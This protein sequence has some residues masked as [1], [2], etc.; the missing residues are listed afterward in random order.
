MAERE[1]RVLQAFRGM[2]P[3][4]APAPEVETL[5]FRVSYLAATVVADRLE[6]QVEPTWSLVG[7]IGPYT[8]RFVGDYDG[9]VRRA[10]DRAR[11]MAA[12]RLGYDV[13]LQRMG[14]MSGGEE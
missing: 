9:A 12:Y 14:R 8:E 4:D 13:V 6:D 1:E 2:L 5:R 10:E 11:E 7:N 3:N